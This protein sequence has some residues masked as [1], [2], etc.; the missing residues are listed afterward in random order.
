MTPED[1][2]K[3]RR[4]IGS[5][6]D[7]TD[8]DVQWIRENLLVDGFAPAACESCPAIVTTRIPDGTGNRPSCFACE[9]GRQRSMAVLLAA[10]EPEP[11]AGTQ[12]DLLAPEGTPS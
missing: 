7:L 5:P 1:R 6:S 10:A 8:A 12:L 11:I 2:A 3:L 9:V 4:M